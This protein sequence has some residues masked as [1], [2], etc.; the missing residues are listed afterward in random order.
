[1]NKLLSEVID[2]LPQGPAT[3][4]HIAVNPADYYWIDITQC[5]SGYDATA[6]QGKFDYLKEVFKDDMPVHDQIPKDKFFIPMPFQKVAAY[7][8]EEGAVGVYFI[9]QVVESYFY[10]AEFVYLTEEKTG[11]FLYRFLEKYKGGGGVPQVKLGTTG[12]AKHWAEKLKNSINERIFGNPEHAED[13]QGYRR[14][15]EAAPDFSKVKDVLLDLSDPLNVA[16]LYELETEA[17]F[18]CMDVAHGALKGIVKTFVPAVD[19][20]SPKLNK[21]REKKGKQP[22]FVWEE[23]ILEP[24]VIYQNGVKFLQAKRGPLQQGHPRIGHPRRFF[25]KKLGDYRTIHIKGT[26]VGPKQETDSVHDYKIKELENAE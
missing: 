20:R 3:R 15:A 22:L 7:V 6:Y 18:R 12:L 23:K 16:F 9:K 10:M 1:M 4:T 14:L 2:A 17:H 21:K 19:T 13:V 25:D 11:H 24:K 26:W 8:V 5:N